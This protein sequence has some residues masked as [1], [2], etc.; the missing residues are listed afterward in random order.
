M[1]ILKKDINFFMFKFLLFISDTFFTI[2]VWFGEIAASLVG[3]NLKK[4]IK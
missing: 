3:I 1:N 2:S 4:E